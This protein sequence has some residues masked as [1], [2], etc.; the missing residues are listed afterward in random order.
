MALAAFL[1]TSACFPQTLL[2]GLGPGRSEDRPHQPKIKARAALSTLAFSTSFAAKSSA[3]LRRWPIFFQSLPAAAEAFLNTEVLS[4]LHVLLQAQP[5]PRFGSPDSIPAHSSNVCSSRA[6]WSPLLLSM[7]FLLP[8][9][10]PPLHSVGSAN[11]CLPA[12]VSLSPIC[13]LLTLRRF[14]YSDVRMKD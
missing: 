4:I 11:S 12:L 10:S 6:A 2:S 5:Q 1:R 13:P 9:C 8:S 7:R 3:P 14:C